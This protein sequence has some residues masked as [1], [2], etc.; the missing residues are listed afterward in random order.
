LKNIP[1]DYHQPRPAQ[2]R[3]FPNLARN[4]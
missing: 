3:K 4:S 1:Y 2:M